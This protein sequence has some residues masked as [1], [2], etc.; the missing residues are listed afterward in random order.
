VDFAA[1][2]A[3]IDGVYAYVLAVR[4]LAA[5]QMLLWQPVA[6]VTAALAV[7][8]LRWLFTRHG[9]PLVLKTDNGSAFIAAALHRELQRWG[10]SQLFSPPRCPGYNGAIE[11][12]IGALKQRTAAQC[13]VAGH[14]GVWTGAA[15]T[16]ARQA[17]NTAHPRRLHGRTPDQV[18]EARA[19]LTTAERAAFAATVEE[20]RAEERSRRDWPADVLLSRTE[21]AAVDRVALRRAL[22]AH[23]L[24]LFR[25]RR[26][27]PRITRPKAATKQ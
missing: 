20:Y 24:L 7:T 21:Q 27:P 19:V 3:L 4:D 11:A 22:V 25:R 16:A 8:E 1:A 15:V 13:L 2:P 6:D 5:G 17:S 9:A 26:I 23:D 12:S 10:V 18:W 14:A